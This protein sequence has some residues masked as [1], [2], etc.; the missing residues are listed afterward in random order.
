VVPR[1]A[2]AVGR[3]PPYVAFIAL[4]DCR[5]VAGLAGNDLADR[6]GHL[7]SGTGRSGFRG[8]KPAHIVSRSGDEAIDR[9]C[10]S[11]GDLAHIRSC[12]PRRLSGGRRGARAAGSESWPSPHT[13][14]AV[15]PDSSVWSGQVEQYFADR[16]SVRNF[17]ECRP[18]LF[19]G[20]YG[21]D[22]GGDPAGGQEAG[23]FLFVAGEFAGI[24]I[25]EL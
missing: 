9:T 12:A 13:D 21:A 22:M 23:E 17:L 15:T 24:D 10:E 6:G 3:G 18:R 25:P 5:V 16:A 8:G 19:E 4:G 20:E 2:I 14:D 1:T 7:L 11:P